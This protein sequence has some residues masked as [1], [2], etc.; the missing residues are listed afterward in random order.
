VANFFQLEDAMG[1]Y[2]RLYKELG[3]L[4]TMEME[5]SLLAPPPHRAPNA[6]HPEGITEQDIA[7]ADTDPGAG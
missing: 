3:R 4:P 6:T 7:A 2:N 5:E 1:A